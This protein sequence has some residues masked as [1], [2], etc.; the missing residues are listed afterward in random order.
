[1]KTGRIS[2]RTVLRGW[3]QPSHCPGWR[4]W[5]PRR[6]R[7]GDT[8]RQGRRRR[9]AWRSS[10]FPTA[11]TWP[12]GRP[13]DA[14]PSFQLPADPQ[15]ARGVQG[16]LARPHRPGPAQRRRPRRRP[17]RPCRVAR[18]LPDR[19]IRSRP[20]APTSAS[21]SRSTRSP[22]RRS[23]SHTRIPL[24]RAG[25][26]PRRQSGNCDSG[27]SCAYS[28]NISWRSA[29]TPMAKEINPRLVFDRLFAIQTATSRRPT[30]PSAT[31][32]SKSILDFVPDD[33]QQLQQR[34]G[35]NDRR[36]L[37]EYLT[38]VRELELRIARREQP[39]PR[40]RPRPD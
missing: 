7:A 8:A 39:R 4:R 31:C 18:L 40:S 1:M 22:R 23:A 17:R 32:T 24:A 10:T 15:T 33:A 19:P 35:T 16:R 34:L 36:K 25:H 28:S 11:S 26:R 27:Y 21:G 9:S 37:D 5:R 6:R 13:K 2:R 20:T 12:T 14:G 30:A 38:S 3:E 29:N